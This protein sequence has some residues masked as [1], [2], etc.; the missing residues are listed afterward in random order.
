MIPAVG[1]EGIGQNITY[2]CPEGEQGKWHKKAS[3]DHRKA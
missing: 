1:T 3:R 2:E